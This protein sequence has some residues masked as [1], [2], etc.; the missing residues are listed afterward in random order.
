MK[1]LEM[2]RAYFILNGG[3]RQR[4]SIIVGCF[5]RIEHPTPNFLRRPWNVSNK[6]PWKRN[7][8]Y[9]GP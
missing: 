3:S 9:I 8:I 5:V 7:I 4:C 2:Q 6:K 1:L